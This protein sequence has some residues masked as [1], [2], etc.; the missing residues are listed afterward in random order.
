MTKPEE[1]II[2]EVIGEATDIP[3]VSAQKAPKSK[4]CPNCENSGKLC[5]VCGKYRK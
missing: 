3:E 5:S 2:N 1:I 4:V